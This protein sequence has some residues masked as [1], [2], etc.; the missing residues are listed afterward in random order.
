MK[1]EII[2]VLT[3]DQGFRLK[4]MEGK[5]IKKKNIY[6]NLQSYEGECIQIERYKRTTAYKH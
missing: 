1:T 2:A 6:L 5:M 3:F 4:R